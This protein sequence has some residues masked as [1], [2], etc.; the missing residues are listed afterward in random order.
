MRRLRSFRGL[1]SAYWLS[2][3]W[4]EAWALT[5]LVFAVTTLLSK[6]SVWTATASADFIAAIAGFH[7]SDA[8]VD[9]A[10][11]LLTA[12]SV[13]LAIVLART[14]GQALRHYYSATLHR[15]ARSWLAAQFD[16]A[17]LSDERVAF[18]L[19]SD[20]GE[21]G[22]GRLPD[23]IDQRI[24]ECTNG[25]YGG[26][27]GL[28]MGIWGAIASIWF[29]SQAILQRSEQVPA[30]DRWAAQFSQ[31]LGR[32]F[33]PEVAARIDLAPGTYG[34]AVLVALLVLVFVPAATAIAWLIGRV[35]ERQT[36]ERQRRDGAWRG[37]LGTM[38]HR[39]SQLAASRGERVQRQ[40]NARLYSGVDDTWGRQNF[41]A[42]AMLMFTNIYS[43]LSQ[44][45]LAYLPA[46]PAFMAG[47]LSFRNY[48]ASSELTAELIS[49]VSWFIT[50]MPA[51]ATLRAHAIRLNELADAVERV[52]ERDRF[53][54]ET[55]VSKFERVRVDSRAPLFI[56]RLRLHH[57]GHDN[58]PFLSVP[59]LVAMPGDWIR[60][61]GRNG[62]GKSSL[63]KA[64]AGLWPYGEGRVALADR[65][66]LFF[67]GQEPD[68]PDRL[69]LKALATYPDP[70]DAFDDIRVA[71]ALANV[72]LGA[73]IGSMTDE[74]YHGKNWRNV[75][76]GGQKQRLV[77]ARILLHRPDVLL[78]DEATSALD[79]N[80]AVDFHLTLRQSLPRAVILAVL[81]GDTPPVDPD[82]VPFYNAV[83]DVQDGVALTRPAAGPAVAQTRFAAE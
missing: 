75:F 32:L 35:M 73:F 81:H 72:G 50:V 53:Y 58:D 47:G 64:V 51:I 67:A 52:Q 4:K 61:N 6:A 36:L 54:A 8:G 43:F 15:K 79:V 80:A 83:L 71:A 17:I 16:D 82:G 2:D 34:T 31:A 39:V 9:P 7:S 44:R 20:R 11:T 70:E 68:L 28:A 38:L 66:R 5:A 26:L 22:G 49:D 42:A 56:E 27:I 74:L 45:L 60:L 78:L 48:A 14:S 65:A 10:K 30:L 19:M 23:A 63:L 24:D 21:A 46:L 76:S 55:G 41:W 62:C 57:R 33:G 25:L 77:L 12:G 40:V 18:D 37:E 69:S 3:R 59:R 29:V 1:V 13:Y